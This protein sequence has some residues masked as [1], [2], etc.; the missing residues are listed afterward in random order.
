MDTQN[1]SAQLYFKQLPEDKS[2][3]SYNCQNT[4]P[5][6]STCVDNVQTDT[7]IENA[8]QSQ[9]NLSEYYKSPEVFNAIK[10]DFMDQTM[11][12]ENE[13]EKTVNTTIYPTPPSVPVVQ[14]VGPTDFLT[15]FLNLTRNVYLRQGFGSTGSTIGLLIAFVLFVFFMFILF[16]YPD[17]FASFFTFKWLTSPFN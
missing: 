15:R 8:F 16:M 11:E 13:P 5:N 2:A 14:T 12:Y 6:L 9:L 4:Y 3:A 7:N 1:V 17:A 10:K